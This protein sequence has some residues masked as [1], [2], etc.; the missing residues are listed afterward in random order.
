MTIFEN[1][2]KTK[3]KKDILIYHF[4]CPPCWDVGNLSYEHQFNTSVDMCDVKPLRIIK[5]VCHVSQYKVIVAS[6]M[7]ISH[8]ASL[9]SYN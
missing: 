3:R 4:P 1:K 5:H 9:A 8:N 2:L 6:K 7:C